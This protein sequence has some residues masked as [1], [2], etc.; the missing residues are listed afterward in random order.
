MSETA[1]TRRV[2]LVTGA[3]RGIGRGIALALAADGVDIV[4]N[5]F[6]HMDLAHS[7]VDEIRALGREAIAV[8]ADVSNRDQVE[9]VVHQAVDHFG[10]LDIAVANAARS[11]RKP[12]IDLTWDEAMA[13]FSVALFGVWHTCQFAA[14]QMVR[15]GEGGKIIIIGSVHAEI[16]VRN[17]ATY[18][19]CKAGV[20]HL[21]ATLANELAEHRI[22]VNVINP[23]WIDT[24]GERAFFSEEE[25]RLGGERIPWGRLG[26]IEDMGRVATFLASPAAD[27]VTG[28]T[29]RADGGFALRA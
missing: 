2:A 3:A 27:Y 13:T 9:A 20:N 10:R 12:F 14:R 26:T 8:Q 23:G 18:N 11:L 24:P 6:A 15:Q 28:A 19:T 16:P 22:N 21:A 1:P 7:V 4:V 29:L 5:D 17:S 25:I